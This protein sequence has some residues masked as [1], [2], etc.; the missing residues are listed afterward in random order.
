[1]L[2]VIGMPYN[3]FATFSASIGMV[4]RAQDRALK[5]CGTLV[6]GQFTTRKDSHSISK[7][8]HYMSMFHIDSVNGEHAK[9]QYSLG[10]L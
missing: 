8:L 9:Y 5:L 2:S 4:C 1:M 10:L 3:M 7:T 6:M